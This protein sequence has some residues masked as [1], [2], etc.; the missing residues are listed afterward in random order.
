MHSMALTLMD[1]EFELIFLTTTTVAVVEEE[2]L[3]GIAEV[4]MIDTAVDAKKEDMMTEE[5]IDE[6]GMMTEEMIDGEVTTTEEM[7]DEVDMTIEEMTGEEAMTIEKMIGEMTEEVMM[8]A[9]VVV[10]TE[11]M[12]T[13]DTMIAETIEV[14]ID[15]VMIDEADTV[16]AET[17]VEIAEEIT[18]T[19]V[20]VKIKPLGWSQKTPTTASTSQDFLLISLRTNWQKLL[21]NLARLHEE[22]KSEDTLISGRGKFQFIRKMA[23]AKE[24]Q[25]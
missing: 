11:D 21:V 1:V 18:M 10:M 9:E 3:V 20:V 14:M 22:S 16:T 5:T 12:M 8:T 15:E 2:M 24:M 13:V 25:H 19:G 4:V 23:N 6:E 17:I 7:I